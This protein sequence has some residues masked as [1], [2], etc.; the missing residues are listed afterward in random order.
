MYHRKILYNLLTFLKLYAMG[1]VTLKT[2]YYVNSR[3]KIDVCSADN[4]LRD[5][6]EY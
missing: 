4:K 3:D 6:D 2:A 5:N 1:D